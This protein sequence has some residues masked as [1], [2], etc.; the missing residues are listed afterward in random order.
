MDLYRLWGQFQP[1]AREK[2]CVLAVETDEDN[3]LLISYI[4]QQLGCHLLTATDRVKALSLAQEHQPDLILLEPDL[5]EENSYELIHSFKSDTLTSKIPIIA[6]TRL[7]LPEERKAILR[8]GCDACLG[9]P[10][11]IDALENL[12]HS[13]LPSLVVTPKILNLRH[14]SSSIMP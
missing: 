9:K 3:L 1:A 11:L 7:V 2:P 13:Y 4:V 10:Y 5:P 8:A 6:L 14:E 12:L